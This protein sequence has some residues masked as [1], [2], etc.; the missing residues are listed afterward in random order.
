MITKADPVP[1]SRP[2]LSHRRPLHIA[3]ARQDDVPN[4]HLGRPLTSDVRSQARSESCIHHETANTRRHYCDA[5]ME[6]SCI[7]SLGWPEER[8][9]MRGVGLP[10]RKK[11]RR[12]RNTPRWHGED[13]TTCRHGRV[14]SG[15]RQQQDPSLANGYPRALHYPP[16]RLIQCPLRLHLQ[17]AYLPQQG[18]CGTNRRLS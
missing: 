7:C 15:M 18:L 9:F 6:E 10:A 17:H 13:W 2:C 4:Y 3:P 1:D 5:R 8:L 11:S 16:G 14:D 12:A